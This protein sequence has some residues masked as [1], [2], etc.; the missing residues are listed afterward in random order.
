MD[1]SPML[2]E[3]KTWITDQFD[4]KVAELTLQFERTIAASIRELPCDGMQVQVQAIA[5]QVGKNDQRLSNSKEFADKLD[6]V[7][8]TKRILSLSIWQLVIGGLGIIGI[9]NIPWPA[10]IKLFTK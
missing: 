4:S 1:G 7:K 10:I 2:E 3:D 8:N 5:L 9:S 6:N